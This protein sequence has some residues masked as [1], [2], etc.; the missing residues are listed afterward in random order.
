M[1]NHLGQ[2]QAASDVEKAV[3]ADLL[4]RGEKKRSTTEIGDALAKAVL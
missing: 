1:L 3:A 2:S 4:S